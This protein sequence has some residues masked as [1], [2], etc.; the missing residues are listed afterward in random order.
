MPRAVRSRDCTIN[1]ADYHFVGVVPDVQLCLNFHIQKLGDELCDV[2]APNSDFGHEFDCE[3]FFC[4]IQVTN[5][6]IFIAF[7]GKIRNTTRPNF[8]CLICL[9]SINH[10]LNNIPTSEHSR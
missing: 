9:L 6:F 2:L 10:H 3:N 1:I 8:H 4:S 5:D 7:I